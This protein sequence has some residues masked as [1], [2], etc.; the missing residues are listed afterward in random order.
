MKYLSFIISALI[1]ISCNKSPNKNENQNSKN[2]DKIYGKKLIE[3]G[4]LDYADSLSVDSL[5]IEIIESFNIYNEDNNRFAHIDAEELTEFN[6]DFFIPQL[7][8]ILSKRDLRLEVET[9]SDFES[10]ND[11]LINGQ[12]IKLYTNAELETGAFWDSGPRNF[13]RKV[14]DILKRQNIEER[15]Y[16]LNGGNDLHTF[17]LTENQFTIISERY[18]DEKNEIP[19]L[20]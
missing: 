4:F 8:R 14:N 12:K 7:N 10:S 19:Y 16:L 5:K 6:F 18:K 3:N 1:F 17:L 15:F 9:A 13:F 11:I 20:P 2:L